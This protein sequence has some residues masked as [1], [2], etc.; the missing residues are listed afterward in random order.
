[1]VGVMT[2]TIVVYVSKKHI[3]ILTCHCHDK[4]FYYECMQSFLLRPYL[5]PAVVGILYKDSVV[6]LFMDICPFKMN[7]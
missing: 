3:L 6:L 2:V 7:T 1:M 4:S 5:P